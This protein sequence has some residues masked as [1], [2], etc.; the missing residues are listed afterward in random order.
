LKHEVNQSP[1][2][3]QVLLAVGDIA[4]AELYTE[5]LASVGWQ[6]DVVHDWR[7]TQER[8]LKSLPDVL[9]LDSLP[10][11][12]QID[13]LEKIRRQK[14]ISG[15]PVVLLTDTLETGDLERAKALGVQGFLIKTRA[16]RQ[17]LPDTLRRLLGKRS[18]ADLAQN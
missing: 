9:V 18:A 3:G 10:D 13:A 1:V 12:K 2:A 15:L 11:L 4:F 17:T 8:L 14:A 5:T 6:V 16:T 7:S